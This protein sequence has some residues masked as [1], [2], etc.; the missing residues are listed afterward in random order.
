LLQTREHILQ[1]CER[2]ETH[3]HILR[4]VSPTIDL[5]VILGTLRGTKALSKFI[6]KTGAFSKGGEEVLEVEED[7]QHVD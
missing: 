1:S 3:R 2:Y 6:A 7:D 4:H 5:P